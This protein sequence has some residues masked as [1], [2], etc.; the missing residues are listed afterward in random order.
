MALHTDEIGKNAAGG[1]ELQAAYL[2]KYVDK[3]LLDKFQIVIS[4]CRELQDKPR[5]F[6]TKDLHTDPEVQKLK[7]PDFL[8]KFDMVIHNSDW[9]REKYAD[10]LGIPP[11]KQHVIKNAIE[12][13]EVDIFE[14]I[15]PK[16]V[17]IIYSSTPQR[18]LSILYSAFCELY[19]DDKNI[20]LN[21][22]S[23]FDIY[24]HQSRNA[25]FLPLFEKCKEHPG[26]NYFGSVPHLEL[27]KATDENHILGLPSIWPE[28]SCITAMENM[29]AGNLIVTNNLGALPET[30]AGF[31]LQ[32]DFVNDINSH[33][34]IFY[35]TLKKGIDLIRNGGE[36]NGRT[37]GFEKRNL[38]TAQKDYADHF[39][40]WKL[41]GQEW[42]EFLTGR[43]LY[44]IHTQTNF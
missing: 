23:S 2:E 14:K 15:H 26:I 38:L 3:A 4:R 11:E 35:Y 13:S 25:P 41:R 39:Y 1:T 34:R 30:T 33:A 40:N 19:N 31:A 32:Y 27:L 6:W 24:G 9:Q 7:D 10:Y 44:N 17:K 22:Y 37:I 43:W 42:T 28:T 29:S 12:P 21:V 20:E 16:K 8:R 5:L 18:G 36:I